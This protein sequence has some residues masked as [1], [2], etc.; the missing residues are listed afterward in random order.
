MR[1]L[2]KYVAMNATRTEL[3]RAGLARVTLVR[4][5]KMGKVKFQK[6]GRVLSK[7]AGSRGSRGRF[8][9]GHSAIRG[10]KMG[11]NKQ[12]SAVLSTKNEDRH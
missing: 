1:E 10:A 5:L 11:K 6:A 8:S 3:G 9:M 12:I 2:Q 7:S 4:A